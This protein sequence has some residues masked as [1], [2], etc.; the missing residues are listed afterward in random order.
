MSGGFGGL[1]PRDDNIGLASLGD[2]LRWPKRGFPEHS[3]RRTLAPRRE[4]D[5]GGKAGNAC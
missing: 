3:R 1:H 2:K 5:S 4:G